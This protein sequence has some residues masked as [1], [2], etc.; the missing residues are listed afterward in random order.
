MKSAVVLGAT[1]LVG[2]FI[3]QG[4]VADPSYQRIHLL[5]RR[6]WP[7]PESAKLR[8]GIADF[9]RPSD[10]FDQIA[11]DD[12]QDLS[13]TEFFCALGSTLKNAG[14]ESAFRAIDFTAVVEFAREAKLRGVAKAFVVSSLGANARSSVFYSRVKGECEE[15]LRQLNFA[16]LHVFRP[17]LL[18]GA[19]NEF[20]LGEKLAQGLSKF[21]P[22]SFLGPLSKYR[23]IHASRVAKA[24]L[25]VAAHRSRPGFTVHESREI[26]SIAELAEEGN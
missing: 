10:A 21:L 23:P 24:M 8:V 15:A 18:L 9:S 1:G 4:L 7:G 12:S 19:R 6:P 14:S 2:S 5:L 13:K 11:L 22:F 3:V 25:E 16:E 26:D 20:R 17:S